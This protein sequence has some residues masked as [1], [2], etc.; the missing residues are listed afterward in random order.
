MGGERVGGRGD[1]RG[2]GEWERVG[3]RWEGSGEGERGFMMR[4]MNGR[5]VKFGSLPAFVSHLFWKFVEKGRQYLHWIY[6]SAVYH[7]LSHDP[8]PYKSYTDS[9]ASKW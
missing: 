3:G 7:Q 8:P 9:L 2:R 6:H 5:G 4:S 1:G